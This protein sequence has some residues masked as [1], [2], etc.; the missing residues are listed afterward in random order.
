MEESIPKNTAKKYSGWLSSK[1][2][3]TTTR[4]QGRPITIALLLLLSITFVKY[5][6]TYW[7]PITNLVFD[8]YQYLSPRNVEDFR[9]VIVDIDDASLTALGR[10][11]WPRTRLAK[12]T[13]ATQRL[14]VKA[15][16][17]DIIMPEPDSLSPDV[18]FTD[19]SD[20]SPFVKE[21]LAK[22]PSN[23]EILAE[24]LRKTPSVIAR[25]A[26]IGDAQESETEYRQ[27]PVMVSGIHPLS[28]LC[29]I[30]DIWPTY[31]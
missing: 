7:R 15:I 20:I 31:P 26:L 19:R 13:E 27:T 4:G 28:I 22:L 24:V 25:A 29:L 17:F 14:G 30:K 21:K 1:I 18:I 10:W 3:I 11:P 9:V 5:E 16:G 12:L 6:T 2:Y 23:D 8:S